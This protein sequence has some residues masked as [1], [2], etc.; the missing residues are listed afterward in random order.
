MPL[1]LPWKL[2]EGFPDEQNL[3]KRSMLSKRENAESI[4]A[5]SHSA[6]LPYVTSATVHLTT[7]SPASTRSLQQAARQDLPH[8]RTYLVCV[9]LLHLSSTCTSNTSNMTPQPASDACARPTK[10]IPFNSDKWVP[11]DPSHAILG[12]VVDGGAGLVSKTVGGTDWWRTTER[13]ST[14]GPTLGFWR[15]IGAGFE[16][17][18]D[19]E[20]D[21]RV[22]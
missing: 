5:R 8:S 6:H 14:N 4:S 20:V 10:T 18:V 2:S 16:A 7:V 11:L 9:S 12:Q 19:I 17:A 22:Q 13:H 3:P 1:V 15:E 21:P